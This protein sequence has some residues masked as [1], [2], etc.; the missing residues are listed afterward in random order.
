VVLRGLAV[1]LGFEGLVAANINLNQ[2]GLGFGL[3]GKVDLQ[4]ALII[5]SADLRQ[6]HGTGQR[7]RP[8][9]ASVLPSL[10]H[11]TQCPVRFNAYNPSDKISVQYQEQPV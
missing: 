11:L 8:G 4:H 1:S 6:I 10:Q 3:L 9:E 7:E 5:A 2:L